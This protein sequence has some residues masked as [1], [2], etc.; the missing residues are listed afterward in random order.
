M[1][2]RWSFFALLTLV[3]LCFAP[4]ASAHDVL[5]TP[6]SGYANYQITSNF[7]GPYVVKLNSTNTYKSSHSVLLSRHQPCDVFV[8]GQLFINGVD[9]DEEGT[10][11]TSQVNWSTTLEFEAG[12]IANGEAKTSTYVDPS[13]PPE[14]FVSQDPHNVVWIL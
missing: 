9:E 6:S 12:V 8:F 14:I 2:I 11:L 1:C 3:S 7:Q 13:S 10:L 4:V 5:E